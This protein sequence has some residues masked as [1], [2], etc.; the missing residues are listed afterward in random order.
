MEPNKQGNNSVM[1]FPWMSDKKYKHRNK[2]KV[3][4]NE[5]WVKH[6]VDGKYYLK[7]KT[8]FI[9]SALD[10]LFDYPRETLFS[11]EAIVRKM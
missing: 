6:G 5:L 11:A 1:L 2:W 4:K 7:K 9:C 10:S 3:G 8:V